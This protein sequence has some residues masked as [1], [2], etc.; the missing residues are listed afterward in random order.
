MKTV[1]GYGLACVLSLVLAACAGFPEGG[2]GLAG[3]APMSR[4]LSDTTPAEGAEAR[5]RVHVDLGIAY[6][7]VGRYDVALD[8]ARV[9]LAESSSYP[10]AHHLLGLAY[11]LVGETAQARKGFE[12]ALRQAPGDPEFNNSYGWF[13]CTQGE[14]RRGLEHLAQA[15]RNPYY[16]YPTRSYVNSGWCHL[17]LGETEAAQQAFIA[18]LDADS[19]NLEALYALAE[20]AYRGADYERAHALLTRVH[21]LGAPT[22]ASVWLGLRTARRL[23]RADAES[24]YAAQL[25]SRF[26]GSEEYQ[27]MKR[28]EF[29]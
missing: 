22:P 14:E 15:A 8:E 3:S 10:P 1:R 24:S 18:A 7:E 29:E 21:Q 19:A 20:I 23:G 17:R 27:K 13:L 5:A 2:A 12:Q 16:R 28:G 6:F 9:A 11:M 26:E 4:P 25:S